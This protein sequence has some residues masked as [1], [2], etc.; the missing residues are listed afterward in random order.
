VPSHDQAEEDAV[1]E[2]PAPVL[3]RSERATLSR[4]TNRFGP[5]GRVARR[6]ATK[7][8]AAP[9]VSVRRVPPAGASGAASALDVGEA[10]R[11]IARIARRKTLEAR[12]RGSG[13]VGEAPPGRPTPRASA[14]ARGGTAREATRRPSLVFRTGDR[15]AGHGPMRANRAG[16]RRKTT[17]SPAAPAAQ[18]RGRRSRFRFGAP[19]RGRL[20]RRSLFDVGEARRAN[21][22]TARRKTPEARC[23]GSGLEC[24]AAH[25]RTARSRASAISRRKAIELTGAAVA[26]RVPQPGSSGAPMPD[27]W[28]WDLFH[29]FERSHVE[30]MCQAHNIDQSN[31]SLTALDSPDIVSVQVRQLCE[32][33]LR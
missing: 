26:R 31:I 28:L 6:M 8:T 12:F 24:L 27:P 2:M 33:L 10:R 22:A 21:R 3:V 17:E 7:S 11:A 23:R 25:E 15:V 14:G 20:R 1:G 30:R 13:L 4:V 5:I 29:E 18:G 19:P 32:E 9:A 16:A